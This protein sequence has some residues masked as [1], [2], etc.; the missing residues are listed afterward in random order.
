MEN[1]GGEKSGL[2]G[3]ERTLDT[4]KRG[5]K[6]K[7]RVGWY[8]EVFSRRG[9]VARLKPLSF[10]LHIERTAEMIMVS[11][12]VDCCNQPRVKLETAVTRQEEL[13]DFLQTTAVVVGVPL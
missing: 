7:T 4:K 2:V 3:I 6:I 11:L 10:G 8:R 12:Q 9:G 13:R 1:G 5:G